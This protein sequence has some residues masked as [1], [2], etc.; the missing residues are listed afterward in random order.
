MASRGRK[1]FDGVL[2]QD[3]IGLVADQGGAWYAS[4]HAG[5]HLPLTPRQACLSGSGVQHGLKI[6]FAGACEDQARHD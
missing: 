6:F 2:L 5:P 3:V 4:R 1:L